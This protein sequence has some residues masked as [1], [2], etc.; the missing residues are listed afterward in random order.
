[1]GSMLKKNRRPLQIYIDLIRLIGVI[2]LSIS[3]IQFAAIEGSL[4]VIE[5]A[6]ISLL[7]LIFSPFRIMLPS[8]A[9]FRPG[10]AFILF[11]FLQFDYKLAILAALPGTIASVWGKE[12]P[13]DKFFLMIG[14]LT[15]GIYAGGFV[16]HQLLPVFTPTNYA[17]LAMGISLLLHFAVN[18]FVAAIIVAYRKQHGLHTQLL[19]LVKDLNWGYISTYLIGVMMFLVFQ[20]YHLSGVLLSTILLLAVYR[21]FIYFQK[22][23][24]MEAKVYLD[25]LT[26]AESRLS[27]EE[28]SKRLKKNWS[29]NCGIV[30]MMDLDYFKSIND[31]YGHDVGD[32]IL[33]EFVSYIRKEMN[34]KYRLF[35]F[36]GDEFILFVYSNEKEYK[37]ACEEINQMI[38]QQNEIW[39]KKGLA[40]SVSY[41]NAF[42][43]EKDTIENIVNKADKLMYNDKFSRNLVGRS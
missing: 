41:G 40:V 19:S 4:K 32:R 9:S 30:Y 5:L 23:K 8:G 35:R 42:F 6:A 24:Q 12:R 16:Y 17:F 13:F 20:T 7:F 36:G 15:I 22:M 2:S 38:H 21:S 39:K 26:K 11:S 29:V 33:Q 28:F 25:G 34:R 10:M 31:T 37:G 1:M 43:S 14:H 18:R 3:F 27:W